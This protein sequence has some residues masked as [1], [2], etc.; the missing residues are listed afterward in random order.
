MAN[1]CIDFHR[2]PYINPRAKKRIKTEETTHKEYV[3]PTRTNT[4]PTAVSSFVQGNILPANPY[5]P[6]FP[7]IEFNKY[8]RPNDVT[9]IPTLPIPTVIHHKSSEVEL[10]SEI[11]FSTEINTEPHVIK[12]R[13][14]LTIGEI[15]KEKWGVAQQQQRA[16]EDR[17]QVKQIGPFRYFA[18]F[19]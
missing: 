14:I 2:N 8:V 18:V 15:P 11:T 19:D 3:V 4:F 9:L 1:Y 16:S 5:L 6:V 17:Y 12:K 13:N 7:V 10:S